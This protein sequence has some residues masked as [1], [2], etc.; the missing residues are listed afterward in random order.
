VLCLEAGLDNKQGIGK[1][2]GG[3]T[4]STSS[5]H[6]DGWLLDPIMTLS[7]VTKGGFELLIYGEVNLQG[8]FGC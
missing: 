1:C 7:F 6:V 8:S 3:C 2:K 4:R 5:T